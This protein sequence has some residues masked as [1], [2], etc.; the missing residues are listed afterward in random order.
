MEWLHS[1]ME[2]LRLG[3]ELLRLGPHMELLRLGFPTQN[4]R[5][6]KQRARPKGALWFRQAWFEQGEGWAFVAG[7]SERREALE[8]IFV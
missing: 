6:T 1:G 8:L 3:V 5:D 4:G 7:G 2:L